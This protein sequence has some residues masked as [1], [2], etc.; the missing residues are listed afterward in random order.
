VDEDSF[1]I[2][3]FDAPETDIE[4]TAQYDVGLSRV[5]ITK[6]GR[7]YSIPPAISQKAESIFKKLMAHIFES[8]SPQADTSEKIAVISRHLELEAVQTADINVW[9]KEKSVIE[10]YLTQ[11]L[12][13]FGIIDVLMNDDNIEDIICSRA[14]IVIGI[15]HKNFSEHVMLQTNIV[16]TTQKLDNFIM[17]ISRRFKRHPTASSPIVY[18]ST[19]THDRITIVW[20]EKISPFGSSFAIR[21]FPAEPY[22]ITHLI[23][24]GVINLDIAAYLWMLIDATPFLLI[25]VETGSGKTTAINALMNLSNPRLHVLVLEDTREL[26]IPHYWTEYNTTF[27]DQ[28]A[29]IKKHP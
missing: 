17:I 1:S 5:V 19:D 7:Y 16:F 8:L 21:K 15:I 18:G 27:E 3:R 14:G 26:V 12:V 22:T 6:D 4:I 10:F 25:I 13:G 28:H 9:Q 20:K 29:R 2:T 23:E 11:D 24:S